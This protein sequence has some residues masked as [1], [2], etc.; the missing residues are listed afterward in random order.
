MRP[1][2]ID[3]LEKYNYWTNEPINDG[4]ARP[5]YLKKLT[6][7]MENSLVKVVL[8][9]RRSGKSHLMRALISQLIQTRGIPATNILYINKE[10]YDFNFIRNADDLMAVIE[11]YRQTLQPQNKIYI[12]LDEIQEIQQWEKAVNS[13]AQNHREP[14]EIIITGSNANLLSGELATYLAGRYVTLTIYP[15]SYQEYLHITEQS[16]NKQSLLDY[17]NEGGLPELY[18]LSTDESKF[19]YIQSLLDS[20]VLRDIV[21]RNQIRDVDL[22]EKIIHFVTDSVGSMLSIPSIIKTI[23]EQ[24]YKTNPETLSN[25]L[26]YCEQAYYLHECA[27]YDMRGKQILT[28]EKKYYLNDLAFNKVAHTGFDLRIHRLL[29][30]AIYLSLLRQGYHVFVGRIDNKEIDFVAEKQNEKLYI[31]V[32]YLLHNQ[33]TLEREFNNLLL[34]QDNYPKWVVSLDEN[35]IGNINGILHKPAWEIV[36]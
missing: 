16:R 7:L 6:D 11:L 35:H 1:Q 29:E 36:D 4:Y 5:T 3:I 31:Q 18:Q 32:A 28:G 33:K 27:R 20:I 15:F 17:L 21:Q 30:N 10:L 19:N 34:I 14:A 24:G 9:Q 13:L 8:G 25:Y 22:L 26:H 2:P 12:F 23:K